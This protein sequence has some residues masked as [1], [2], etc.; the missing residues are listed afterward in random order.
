VFEHQRIRDITRICPQHAYWLALN[1]GTR[2]F[3]G[4]RKLVPPEGSEDWQKARIAAH[5]WLGLPK[6]EPIP[7]GRKDRATGEKVT[8]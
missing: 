1:E 6:P 3:D 7:Q 4:D 8:A 2:I 5:E